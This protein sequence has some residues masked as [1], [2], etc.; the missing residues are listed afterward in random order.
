ML[1]CTPYAIRP[2]VG[3]EVVREQREDYRGR[4]RFV[5]VRLVPHLR[6]QLLKEILDH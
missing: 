3:P 1:V 4:E 6:L 5:A 2:S